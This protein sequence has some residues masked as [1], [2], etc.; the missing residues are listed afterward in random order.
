MSHLVEI[1][2][3]VRDPDS[4]KR[5]WRGPTLIRAVKRDFAAGGLDRALG[6]EEPPRPWLTG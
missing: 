5:H 3:E 4:A 2:A 1:K 6:T